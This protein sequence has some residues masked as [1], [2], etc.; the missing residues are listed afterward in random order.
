MKDLIE[1]LSDFLV[2][3]TYDDLSPALIERAKEA[4]ID[5][6]AAVLSGYGE[7]VSDLI[8]EWVREQGGGEQATVVGYDVKS[9]VSLSAFV[10]GVMGHA[11]DYDDV[12][13]PLRGH[14]SLL[15]YASI[16]SIAEAEG[17]S[18]KDMI[19]SFLLGTEAMTKIGMN[20]NPS[21]YLKGWHSTSTVGVIGAAVA[22]GKLYGFTK[23]EYKTVIGLVSSMM[24]G[25]RRN[26]GTMTKSFHVG[27]AARSGVEAA[28]LV[29]KGMTA[30]HH[31]FDSTGGVFDLYSDGLAE[32][33]WKGSFGEPWSILDPGFHTKKY[34]CCY[35]IHRYIDGIL[36]I[37]SNDIAIDEITKIECIGAKGSFAPLRDTPPE[38]GSEGMFSLEYVVAAGLIDGTID[39]NSFT[40]EKVHRENVKELMT[41]VEVN[42]DASIKEDRSAGDNGYIVINMYL[43][44]EVVKIK[45]IN[46][47]GSAMN[48]LT[49]V[50]LKDKYMNCSKKAGLGEETIHQYNMLKELQE[51]N[52]ISEMFN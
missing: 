32:D 47:K 41:K 7:K 20:L 13:P 45:I 14:P 11:I 12:S 16:L 37:S 30:S 31:T 3:I 10:H 9:T 51:K 43:V 49:D 48:P 29:K 42:E 27:N 46:G 1:E 38:T 26:F 44:D 21:H 34:P 25:I 19:L 35:A 50:E 6:H 36:E 39:F 22:A 23:D 28:Q 33:G 24:S 18:G 8:M 52:N 2:N 17:K 5:S 15:V 4:M 40:D